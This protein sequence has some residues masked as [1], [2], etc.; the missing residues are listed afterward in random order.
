M[1]SIN[2][3]TMLILFI[4]IF[5][6]ILINPQTSSQAFTSSAMLWFSSLVP[7]LYPSLLFIDLLMND[8]SLIIICNYLYKPFKYVLNINYPKS[9]ILIILSL[10]C[11]VPGNVKAI[12]LCIKNNEISNDEGNNLIYAYSNMSLA[13]TIYIFNLFDMPFYIYFI[14]SFLFS[15]ILFYILN[16][17]VITTNKS[18][19]FEHENVINTLFKSISKSTQILFTI[20]GIIVLFNILITL[21]FPNG[22]I[23]YP[24]FEILGGLNYIKEKSLSFILVVFALGFLGLSAHMQMLSIRSDLPYFKFLIIRLIYSILLSFIWILLI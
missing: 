3:D 5:I 20:L 7:V 4:I 11:G 18:F 24:I 22:F 8:K 6:L 1:H 23:L 17:K 15:S 10:I 2:C 16:N 12:D 19:E 21:F 9:V 14:I 13:Y